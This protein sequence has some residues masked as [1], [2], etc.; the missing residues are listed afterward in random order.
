MSNS[1][2]LA[3][4]GGI[5]SSAG[6]SRIDT[7][8]LALELALELGGEAP[9][10]L[11][12]ARDVICRASAETSDAHSMGGSSLLRQVCPDRKAR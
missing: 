1:S 3:A 5:L 2:E 9:D 6:F 12:M 10:N 7:R 8:K 11:L 4:E